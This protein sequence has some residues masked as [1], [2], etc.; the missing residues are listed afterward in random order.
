MSFPA[1]DTHRAY[2]IAVSAFWCKSLLSSLVFQP[3]D[4]HQES[5]ILRHALYHNIQQGAVQKGNPSFDALK[6]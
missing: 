5:R 2:L 4:M 1:P 3:R 6:F